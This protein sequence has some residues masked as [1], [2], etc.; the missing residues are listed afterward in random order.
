MVLGSSLKGAK[1]ELDTSTILEAMDKI[2][3]EHQK[4]LSTYHQLL[5]NRAGLTSNLT[6]LNSIN[7]FANLCLVTRTPSKILIPHCN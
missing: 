6:R 4:A 3:S 1:T 5:L 7:F 2:M